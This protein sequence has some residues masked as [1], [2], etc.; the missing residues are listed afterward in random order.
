MKNAN[1]RY[2]AVEL[3]INTLL[4]SKIVAHY[5][6]PSVQALMAKISSTVVT[7]SY[8]SL[9]TKWEESYRMLTDAYKSSGT[10]IIIMCDMHALTTSLDTSTNLMGQSLRKWAIKKRMKSSKARYTILYNTGGSKLPRRF[11]DERHP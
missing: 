5:S 7:I 11:P 10:R 3:V 6:K 4:P 8:I 1:R 2:R 9:K